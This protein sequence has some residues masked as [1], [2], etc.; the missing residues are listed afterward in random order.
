MGIKSKNKY[1]VIAFIISAYMLALSNLSVMDII[2]NKNY[3]RMEPYFTSSEF[4]AE[5]VGY[6]NNIEALNVIYKDYSHKSDDEKVTN[7]EIK[8]S[9]TTYDANLRTKE[10]QL[11]NKY[12][13]DLL[14]AEKKGNNVEISRLTD[15]KDKELNEFKKENEKTLDNAKK[16]IALYKNKDYENIKRAVEGKTIIKYYITKGKNN[17]IYTN[18]VNVSDINLYV[19]NNAFYSMKFPDKSL[20]INND[21]FII[22]QWVGTSGEAYFIIPKDIDKTSYIYENYN[23]YNSVRQ[24]IIKEVIIGFVAFIIWIIL[25]FILKKNKEQMPIIKKLKKWYNKIPLDVRIFIFIIYYFIMTI[26][27]DNVPFFYKPY[28]YA[29]FCTLTIMA[30][31]MVYCISN[32]IMAYG[33]Y[34]NREEFREQVK[35]CAFYQLSKRGIIIL[36]MFAGVAIFV[37][38]ITFMV[39][40]RIT[41]IPMMYIICYFVFIF[42]YSFNKIRFLRNIIK[43]TEEIVSGNLNYTIVEKGGGDLFKLAHNINNMKAGFKKSLENEMKSERLKSELITNVSHDLKTPLTSIINYVDFLKKEGL[44]KEESQGY[45]DVLDRKS[46]RLKILI[47]DLFEASKMA[48]GAVE[49]NIEKVDITA[50]LQ[51]SLAE[52]HDKIN[53]SSLIFKVKVPKQKIYANLDGKKTWRVFENLINNILKYTLPKTRVYIDLIERDNQIII[54]MKNIS[55]YEMDFDNEEIFE[56]FIR[57]DKS[58]NTEGSGLGLSIAK[59]IIDLQGGRLSIEIDGDLFKAKVIIPSFSQPLIEP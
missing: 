1:W 30:F 7:E 38:Y 51:Q 46:Q 37:S 47:D 52:L 8:P 54:N 40:S 32:L 3:L 50:L 45:I 31:Y 29:Q 9:K 20:K 43:G 35:K 59:S 36:T 18:I 5:I 11:S 49:L 12:K 44:S 14:A 22:N 10:D 4:K 19:K 58:R 23:Y 42:I 55:S 26:Y 13:N 2:K 17:V 34:K 6:F 16:K 28:N 48:S 41:I 57:G 53:N 15:A 21:M 25:I 33:L 56:R 27:R 39:S 24:R